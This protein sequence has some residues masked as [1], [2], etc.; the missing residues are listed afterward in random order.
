MSVISFLVSS[1]LTQN[2]ACGIGPYYY[3]YTNVVDVATQCGGC[4]GAGLDCWACLNVQ[5]NPNANQL[6]LDAGLTIPINPGLY[7]LVN[8]MSVGNYAYWTVQNSYPQGGPGFFGGC[9]I[10]PT[11]TPTPTGQPTTPTNTPTVTQTPSVTPTNTGT[12]NT[13]P[14]N[15]P[16][17]SVT[18]SV[19]VSSLPSSGINF[20]KIIT[21]YQKLADS[22][23]QL[24]SFGS[25]NSD[26][27]SYRTQTRDKEYNTQ[28]Q[29]PYYP[30]LFVIPGKVVNDLEYKTW[31]FNT[32]VADVLE[33][34]L[35][36]QVDISSDTLQILQDVISQFRL[37]VNA[38]FGNYYNDYFVDEEVNCTPFLE[39]ED[40]MLNGW[41][42]LI[43]IKTM[44][45]L[46]RC[47]AAYLPFTGTPIQHLN[48]INFK[49]FYEDFKLLADHHKQLNSFGFGSVDDFQYLTQ[50]RDKED[51]TQFQSPYYPLMYV[52]PN[53]VKQKFNYMEYTFDVIVAD[54]MERSLLNQTDI[55]S[56][57]NQI[58]DDII[59]QFRLSVTQSLGNFNAEY[60]LDNPIVCTPFME[61]YDDLLGGWTATLTIQVMTP[62]NRCD[63][64]F[65]DTFVTPTPTVTP[66]NTST[67]T[68]TPSFTPTSSETPTP[69]PT[70]TE[71]QTPTPSVTQT[72]TP[73]V[74]QTQTGTP[75]VTPTPTNTETPTNTPT[76]TET[77]TNTP[78]PTNTE[79]QTPTPTKSM[80]PT[81]TQTQTGTP[82]VT[83]TP[84]QT[85]TPTNSQ[86][87]TN[88]NTPTVTTTPSNTPSVTQTMT[89]TT[90]QTPTVTP[91]N[92]VWNLTTSLWE[93]NT[94]L[95][96]SCGPLVTPTMT[97]T[98]T[99]TPTNTP[100]PSTT[101]PASGT[102]EANLY[103][104]AVVDNG[105]TGITSTVS[106]ATVTLFTS[107]FSNNLYD[108]IKT[109][110]P[111][112]GG[113]SGSTKFNAINPVDTN[114][115][116]RLSFVGTGITYDYS[117]ITIAN[118]AL[119][120]SFYANTNFNAGTNLTG[121]SATV[122]IYYKNLISTFRETYWYGSYQGGTPERF[123]TLSTDV[124]NNNRQYSLLFSRT[125]QLTQTGI[126]YAN[127]SGQYTQGNDG[128]NTYLRYNGTSIATG[129]D[130][131]TRPTNNVYIG[132][133]NLNGTSYRGANARYQFFYISDSLTSDEASTMETI[134]NTFQT[135]IGRNL[136]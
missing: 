30:L 130:S 105:G 66:T 41:N 109:M 5:S 75:A 54:I 6:F 49:T 57:T 123:V 63:A 1:G 24:N 91:A 79:T 55:L 11:P 50:S 45:P 134:I 118:D 101:P 40:D 65:F 35:A 71:T 74:T 51:N 120:G 44:T 33:R 127:M 42:G 4:F 102:T 70:N 104:R 8:E 29:S 117:G 97:K 23:K 121:N 81:P 69:T 129:T 110:Y 83:S 100:T 114:A 27:L 93:N 67:P 136:Y 94:N 76:T 133:L 38:R 88:T 131:T 87:P 32:I 47:A 3:V 17:I 18:P 112:L 16:T 15:T 53:D 92:C 56:D 64:A 84:T 59:S 86:T 62:L 125:N 21:D 72:M 43:R 107:L 28:F 128:T 22:H 37:S 106:A 31:D 77:P 20:R 111:M 12:P 25:G 39:K 19:S 96:N 82:A 89:P 135:S 85:Q 103:L 68:P 14:T 113:T 58:L 126:T 78:T 10:G 90:T 132:T 73:T 36:N 61:Q 34:D 13:T 52:V 99:N 9:P 48:G 119:T 98:P 124:V 80:T 108:K 95:W 60:Y 46:N 116:F 26:Q 2:E 7:Y 115:A 122:G